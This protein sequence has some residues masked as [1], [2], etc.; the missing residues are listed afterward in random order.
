MWTINESKDVLKTVAKAEQRIRDE[1][2]FWKSIVRHAGPD[3]L[4]AVRGM[5]DEAL[6]GQWKGWRASRLSGQWRVIYRVEKSAFSVYVL[7]V[8]PHDYR[9][10]EEEKPMAA[11]KKT[12]FVPERRHAKLTPADMVRMSREFQEMTQ[13]ALAKASGVPQPAIAG[14]ESGRIALRADRAEKLAIALKVHPAVL[15]WPQWDEKV[16][17]R[18][19]G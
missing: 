14:I 18:K 4:R 8:S 16:T 6:S 1:Y 7:R 2:E 12:D 13:T 17:Q 3:A 15:L 19:T 9:K 11:F 5:N 10:E